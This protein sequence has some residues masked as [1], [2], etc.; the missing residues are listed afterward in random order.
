METEIT[1]LRETKTPYL[2][3]TYLRDKDCCCCSVALS[4]LTLFDSMDCS[5]PGLPVPHHLPEFSQVHDHC[6]GDAF[7]ASHPL[8][9]PI[10]SALNVSH[11]QGLFQWVICLNQMTKI[12]ELQHQSFQWIVRVDLPW[13]WLVW[14]PC[15]PRDVQDFRDKDNLP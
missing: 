2:K 5:T 1:Y 15:C 3:I 9:P 6:I 11:H 10:S 8:T 12:L 4:F 13:D 7:P 14:F